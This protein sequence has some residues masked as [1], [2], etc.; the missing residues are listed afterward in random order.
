MA[1]IVTSICIN[2][3]TFVPECEK[4]CAA[5]AIH[6]VGD[7]R[8]IDPVACTDCGYCAPVC[9]VG[10]IY[11]EAL[12]PSYDREWIARNYAWKSGLKPPAD[13]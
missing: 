2:E 9:P 11:P 5:G 1:Y 6:E 13:G 3:M 8:L 4:V 12:V 7:T 10:A